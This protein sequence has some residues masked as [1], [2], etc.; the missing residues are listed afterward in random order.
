M[1][2]CPKPEP[3]A[4]RPRAWNSTLPAP[5]EPIRRVSSLPRSVRLRHQSAKAAA[6]QRVR[7][8]VLQEMFPEHEWHECAFPGCHAEA[9]DPHEPLTRA[10]GG[11]ITDPE[12]IIGLCRRHHDDCHA[13]PSAAAK[14]GLIRHSWNA[15]KRPG[16]AISEA[17]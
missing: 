1:T 11:S 4:P 6:R 9:T 15:G 8:S 17:S 3:A 14:L 16:D 2:A 12:N 13:N 10:R 5:A 7:R